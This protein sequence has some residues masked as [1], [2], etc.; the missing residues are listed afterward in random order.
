M[1]E[2]IARRA[3]WNKR[4]ARAVCFQIALDTRDFTVEIESR[5]WRDL[6][7]PMIGDQHQQGIAGQLAK[8]LIEALLQFREEIIDFLGQ[9]RGTW[10]GEMAGRI[11]FV[12]IE[13]IKGGALLFGQDLR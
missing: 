9:S 6:N 5:F 7:L 2:H 10:T 11:D 4:R 3:G 12:V 13:Q 8:S 1:E